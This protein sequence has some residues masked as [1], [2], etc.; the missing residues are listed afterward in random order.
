MNWRE[1]SLSAALSCR[2]DSV[3]T[4]EDACSVSDYRWNRSSDGRF[5]G[6]ALAVRRAVH[7]VRRTILMNSLYGHHQRRRR[8]PAGRR[9]VFVVEIPP[10]VLQQQTHHDVQQSHR[11]ISYCH[12]RYCLLRQAIARLDTEALAVVVSSIAWCLDERRVTATPLTRHLRSRCTVHSGTYSRCK[13]ETRWSSCD[14]RVSL[15]GRVE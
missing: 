5:A 7:A 6:T 3:A 4:C 8:P 11:G 14:R 15:S 2:R 12:C 1:L 10:S 9:H 13:R